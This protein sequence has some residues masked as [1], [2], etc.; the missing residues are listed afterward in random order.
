MRWYII[1]GMSMLCGFLMGTSPYRDA[2]LKRIGWTKSVLMCI[3]LVTLWP[4]TIVFHLM[5]RKK[6]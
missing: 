1:L 5:T 4:I 2:Y 3:F 6:R